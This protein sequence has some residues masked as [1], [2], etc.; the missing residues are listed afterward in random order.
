M[1]TISVSEFSEIFYSARSN[2][3]LMKWLPG[4]QHMSEREF[5]EQLDIL[6]CTID[7]FHSYTIYIDAYDFNYPIIKKTVQL[8]E[9]FI[10][11]CSAKTLA[12]VTSKH[13]LGYLGIKKLIDKVKLSDEEIQLFN[14]RE[15]GENWLHDRFEQ[16]IIE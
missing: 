2:V 1:N 10:K 6:F 12:L 7:I 15:D 14:S 11:K 4:N 5:N 13:L 9:S 8:I 16:R 3:V